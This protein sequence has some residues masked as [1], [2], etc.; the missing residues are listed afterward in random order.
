MTTTMNTKLVAMKS[1]IRNQDPAIPTA[2]ETRCDTAIT[3]TKETYQCTNKASAEVQNIYWIMP[4]QNQKLYWR[5]SCILWKYCTE[6][7]QAIRN[8]G[9]R[10]ASYNWM[11]RSKFLEREDWLRIWIAGWELSNDWQLAEAF[12]PLIQLTNSIHTFIENITRLH[13]KDR[14]TRWGMTDTSTGNVR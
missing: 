11:T 2:K 8:I 1:L 5:F 13:I 9:S 7:N 12:V 3:T 4:E 14:I 6:K 10:C